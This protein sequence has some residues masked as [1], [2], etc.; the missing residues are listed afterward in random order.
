M[1]Q[2]LARIGW[3]GTAAL[4]AAASAVFISNIRTELTNWYSDVL[5]ED[6]ATAYQIERV[7]NT[8]D[9]KGIADLYVDIQNLSDVDAIRQAI[10]NP[11]EFSRRLREDIFPRYLAGEHATNPDSSSCCSEGDTENPIP[12]APAPY[13]QDPTQ[14]PAPGFTEWRGKEPK[15]GDKG[16]WTNPS[17]GDSLHPDLDHPEP[18]GPHWDW[19]IRS[20]PNAGKVRWFPDGTLKRVK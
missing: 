16:A 7:F 13:P 18:V 6:D 9:F 20:G 17:T 4:G 1:T 2:T 5:F 14:P 19:N 3:T 8:K 11:S 15:G 10:N 12:P